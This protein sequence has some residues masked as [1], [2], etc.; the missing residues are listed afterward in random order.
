[1]SKPKFERRHYIAIAELLRNQIPDDG[2]VANHKFW[3]RIREAMADMFAD[4]NDHFNRP[5]FMDACEPHPGYEVTVAGVE[6]LLK[7][8]AR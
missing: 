3:A 8:G 6:A 7:R 2:S 5:R 4:D 1:M